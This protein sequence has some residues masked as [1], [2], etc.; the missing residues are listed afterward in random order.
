MMTRGVLL[1]LPAAVLIASAL[2][3]AGATA[4]RAF[5]WRTVDFGRI[6]GLI[7]LRESPHAPSGLI[8]RVEG[9]GWRALALEDGALVDAGEAPFMGKLAPPEIVPQGRVGVAPGIPP[10]PTSDTAPRTPSA[11]WYEGPVRRYDHAILGD[12]IE[13]EIL[14]VAFA[15]RRILAHRLGQEHVFE[16]LEPRIVDADGDGD[17]EVLA[18][19]TDLGRGAALALYD[20]EADDRD[21]QEIAATQPVGDRDRWLNP[22]GIADFDGDGRP[23]IAAVLTPHGEGVL[24]HFAWDGESARIV[25]ERRIAGY[26]NHAAGS[27]ALDLSAIHDIDGDGRP[28]LVLPRED[29]AMVAILAFEDGGFE[30]K[31]RI[32]NGGRTI[33]ASIVTVDLDRD[34][35]VEILWGLEDG[36][37]RGLAIPR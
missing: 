26:S 14:Q 29:R 2:L 6:E 16:D 1:A 31:A 22:A 17:L 37:I 21:M 9:R 30:E 8:A 36:A 3:A 4:A 15:D 24:V 34:G 33:T 19:R 10:E 23:E 28:E 7:D 27:T 35:R 18:I 20:A 11:A 13:A 12:A 32:A 25:E 5:D